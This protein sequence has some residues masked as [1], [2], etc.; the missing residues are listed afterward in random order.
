MISIGTHPKVEDPINK[1]ENHGSSAAIRPHTY[2]GQ[3]LDNKLVAL[4]IELIQKGV[5]SVEAA[6]SLISQLLTEIDLS[7]K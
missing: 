5:I 4:L 2:P 7:L 1:T 3:Q 6:A